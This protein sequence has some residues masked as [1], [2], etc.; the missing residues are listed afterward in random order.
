MHPRRILRTP[1][2]L[3]ALQEQTDKHFLR[4]VGRIV[5]VPQQTKA[6][7]PNVFAMPFQQRSERGTI[8]AFP[9]RFGCQLLVGWFDW[10]HRVD[11]TSLPRSLGH[12]FASE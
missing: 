8:R 3:G 1:G 9:R 7:S 4:G 10:F 2:K 6:D 12:C 5:F 11:H